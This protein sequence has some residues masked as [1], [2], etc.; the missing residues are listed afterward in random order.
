MSY[1]KVRY[2]STRPARLA[3]FFLWYK[4]KESAVRRR[5]AAGTVTGR[6]DWGRAECVN[7]LRMLIGKTF[8]K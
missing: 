7:D 8:L 5:P 1:S 4:D 2:C 3:A 6:G